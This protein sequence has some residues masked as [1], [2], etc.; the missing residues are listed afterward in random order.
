M[1]EA[2]QSLTDCFEFKNNRKRVILWY[3]CPFFT[4]N[5]KTFFWNEFKL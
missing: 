3:N 5:W 1:V 4:K 2:Q